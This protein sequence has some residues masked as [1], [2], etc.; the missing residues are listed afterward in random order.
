[1]A[2]EVSSVSV[3]FG[4]VAALKDVSVRLDP[5]RIVTVIGPN[6]SGKSTLFN[7]ITGMVNVAGGTVY[8]DGR[9]VTDEP[10]HRRI[11]AGLGRTFQTPRFDPR[12]TVEEAVLCGFYPHA[13]ASL[14]AALLR[15]SNVTH[16]ER[17]FRKRVAQILADFQ[18]D[19]LKHALVGELP[20]GQVRLVEVAR[21]IAN[22][23]KYILLDEPAAG[24]ARVEQDLLSE[25][26]RRLARAGIGVLL[27][28]H[29]FHMVRALSDHTI[30]LDRG[31]MLIEGRPGELMRDPAFVAAYLGGTVAGHG[32]RP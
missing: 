26:V 32:A 27:V 10:T 13:R 30:V 4:G 9:D 29:N 28:E 2:I 22:E 7:S 21:A 12:V 24:L 6:G 20:M 18:L 11:G 5:G 1:M 19:G 23:P 15:L 17:E 25:E 16:E 31:A 8:V 14:A 3:Q